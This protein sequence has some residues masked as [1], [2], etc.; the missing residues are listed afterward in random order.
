MRHASLSCGDEFLRHEQWERRRYLVQQQQQTLWLLRHSLHTARLHVT[1]LLSTR[2]C[3]SRR[4]QTA[5]FPT[6]A[7]S[8]IIDKRTRCRRSLPLT[9]DRAASSLRRTVA[10]FCYNKYHPGTGGFDIA[11]AFFLTVRKPW[12]S[13]AW[14]GC[15]D[16]AAS[17]SHTVQPR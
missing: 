4:R 17:P 7:D 15:I 1:T 12:R 6:T 11:F 13:V 8:L 2:L 14:L 3:S 5:L 16:R 10:L 9:S